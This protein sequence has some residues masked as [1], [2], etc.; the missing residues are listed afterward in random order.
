MLDFGRR[1][2]N[3]SVGSIQ[4]MFLLGREDEMDKE[5]IVKFV[6]ACYHDC[7]GRLSMPTCCE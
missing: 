3:E 1:H 5:G 7:G 6:K 4:A 2:L